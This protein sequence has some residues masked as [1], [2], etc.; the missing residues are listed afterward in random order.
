MHMCVTGLLDLPAP[1]VLEWDFNPWFSLTPPLARIDK[2]LLLPRD[3]ASENECRTR[4]SFDSEEKPKLGLS[5]SMFA[6]KSDLGGDMLAAPQEV[7]RAVIGA[8]GTRRQYE[9]ILAGTGDRLLQS[10]SEILISKPA[11]SVCVTKVCQTVTL[12]KNLGVS[13]HRHRE[14]L[15]LLLHD[16]QLCK[17][18]RIWEWIFSSLASADVS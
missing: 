17:D 15:A 12:S 4:D 6:P 8:A 5:W 14:R 18:G 3:V 2:M 9:A 10:K 16:P 1:S 13:F 7:S 11:C